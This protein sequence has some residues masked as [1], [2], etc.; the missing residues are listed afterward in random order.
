[1]NKNKKRSSE[2][3]EKGKILSKKFWG[4]VAC[5]FLAFLMW[6]YV[7]Y[8]ENPNSTNTYTNIPVTISGIAALES[9]NI[10]VL[11]SDLQIA[12]K[13]SGAR[14]VLSR[15]S[16]SDINAI[17]DVSNITGTGEQKPIISIVGIPDSLS[18]E[19]KKVTSGKLVTDIL[20]RKTVEVGIDIVG[21]MDDN[22]VEGEKTVSPSQI[23]IKG[24]GTL[25]DK[26]TAWTEP[27]DV[28]SISKSENIYNT[29]IVLKDAAGNAIKSD[30]ITKSEN[31]AT[32]TVNCQSKKEVKVNPPR[33]VGS[34]E[35][36]IVNVE[37]VNPESVV[38]T[39]PVEIVEKIDSVDTADIDAYY[40]MSSKSFV[41]DIILPDEV[42]AETSRI[43]A[44]VS[45]T[46]VSDSQINTTQ[47]AETQ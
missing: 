4:K 20:I 11:S 9:R 12:V 41:R 30:M 34:L 29:A 42:K 39:G 7:S 8:D 13:I 22:I 23:T 19:E 36:Y 33:I 45:I 6:I 14:N 37:S 18:V 35:G 28:S 25:L 3:A 26:V 1:M 44:S 10:T 47:G 32:V 46:P 15:L 24:P 2:A 40:A 5:T 16:K 21:T 31:E 38:I 17:V 43:T 27:I